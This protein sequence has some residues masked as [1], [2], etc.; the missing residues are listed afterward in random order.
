MIPTTRRACQETVH[1]SRALK[2]KNKIAAVLRSF[3]LLGKVAVQ[4]ILYPKVQVGQLKAVVTMEME[5]M[6]EIILGTAD[7]QGDLL[8]TQLEVTKVVEPNPKE[9]LIHR[10]LVLLWLVTEELILALVYPELTVAHL[11]L[12]LEML[13]AYQQIQGRRQV[14]QNR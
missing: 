11:D 1:L 3:C 9:Q 6:A 5:I 7:V 2:I 8:E 12:Q 14:G 10:L 13:L 4:L